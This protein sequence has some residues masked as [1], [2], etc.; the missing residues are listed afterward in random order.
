MSIIR[1]DIYY[2][3]LGVGIGSEQNGMRPVLVIQNDMGNVHSPTVICAAITAQMNKKKLPTHVAFDGKFVNGIR[4]SIIMLEQVRV[5]DKR[6]L[7]E[8]ITH[9]GDGVQQQVDHAIR[10]SLGV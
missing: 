5:I 10:I 1:G 6:R 3:D 8:Y 7:R 2:A 4:P 9:I